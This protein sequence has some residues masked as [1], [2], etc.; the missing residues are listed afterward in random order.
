MMSSIHEKINQGLLSEAYPEIVEQLRK[1]PS[2]LTMRDLF[3]Q[4]LLF[5]G[6]WER[7]EKQL[8]IIIKEKQYN[9]AKINAFRQM[10]KAE[11]HRHQIFNE[12]CDI[13]FY[14]KYSHKY[15]DMYQQA[16]IQFHKK[17]YD[18]AVKQLQEI[19]DAT[20]LPSAVVNGVSVDM[21]SNTDSFLSRFFEVFI[22]ASYYW[23]PF[24]Q[25]KSLIISEPSTLLDLLWIPTEIMTIDDQKIQALLAALYPNSAF[26][27]NDLIKVGYMT[28]WS[29]IH[30]KIVIGSGQQVFETNTKDF[31]L[32][33]IR[34]IILNK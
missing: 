14:E 32:L 30:K 18:A 9:P 3:F 26:H 13:P 1:N 19:N 29:E 24:D 10:I 4:I 7:A 6:Q 33:E 8:D 17:Q 2:N 22:N 21:F 23:F 11:M 28:D 15:H 20:P 34:S 31:S 16:M 27:E 5:L 12:T 25:V